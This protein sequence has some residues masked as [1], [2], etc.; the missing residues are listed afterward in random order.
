M[1]NLSRSSVFPGANS[2]NKSKG[3]FG[4]LLMCR[5]F[6]FPLEYKIDLWHISDQA[7]K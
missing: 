3:K 1:L 4:F 7:E 5:E 6:Y 2:E